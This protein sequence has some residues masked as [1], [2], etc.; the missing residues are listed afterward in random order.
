MDFAPLIARKAERFRELEAEIASGQLYDEPRRARELLREHTRLKEL[1]SGWELLNKSRQELAENQELAKGE[2][3]EMAEMAAAEIPSLEKQIEEASRAVQYALLP[4]DPNEDR[5]AIVEIRAGTGGDEA[6]L[7]GADLYRMYTR[8]AEAH[9][10]KIEPLESSAGGLGGM[11]EVIFKVTGDQVF[12][13]L[14]YESGVH[15]V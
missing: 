5:D 11:K 7:F 12:R 8:Y 10:F 15:R 13:T 3:A 6:A 1:L 9:G 2:D 4:P 14:R